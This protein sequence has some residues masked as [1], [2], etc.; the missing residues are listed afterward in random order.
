[1]SGPLDNQ[2]SRRQKGHQ[3][4]MAHRPLIKLSDA[5]TCLFGIA[6][7][8]VVGAVTLAILAAGQYAER[9]AAARD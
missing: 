6:L 1:V 3:H 9:R 8:L 7:D 5:A 2:P 4:V